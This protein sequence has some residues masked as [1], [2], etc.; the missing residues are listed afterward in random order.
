MV[1]YSSQRKKRLK[2]FLYFFSFLRLYTRIQKARRVVCI[3]FVFFS[4]IEREMREREKTK[5]TLYVHDNIYDHWLNIGLAF[6][7]SNAHT[8]APK[9]FFFFLFFFFQFITNF[10]FI[11][12]FLCEL[13]TIYYSLAFSFI[14]SFSSGAQSNRFIR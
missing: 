7:D 14:R 1:F 12:V 9:S 11:T 8:T 2:H 3:C 4:A 13:N 10:F 5:K 6:N